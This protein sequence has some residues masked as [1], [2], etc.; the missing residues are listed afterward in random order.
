ME[1]IPNLESEAAK[2]HDNLICSYI[3]KP[4][5]SEIEIKT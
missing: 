4:R 1:S 3:I 2:L 5:E